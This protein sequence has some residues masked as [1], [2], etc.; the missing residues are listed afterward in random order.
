MLHTIAVMFLFLEAVGGGP[1][2]SPE[3]P[4]AAVPLYQN[5]SEAGRVCP[6]ELPPGLSL[7]E[8]G[9]RWAPR[10]FSE[11]PDHPQPYREVF[12]ALANGKLGESREF[13]TAHR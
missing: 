8:L 5:G 1:A 6:G 11:T 7:L 12:I 13:A 2:L 4:C 10:I 9:D 3:A